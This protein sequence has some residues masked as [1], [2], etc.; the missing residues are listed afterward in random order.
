MKHLSEH[1]VG[2]VKIEGGIKTTVTDVDPNTGAVSWDVEYAADYLKLYKQVQELF[3][4]VNKAS[5][6]SNAEPFIKDWGQDVRQLRNSLRT[7]LRNNKAEEYARVKNM[8]EEMATG[9]T[10]SFNVGTG[11]QY[12]TK[13]AFRKTE[14][15]PKESEKLG[16]KPVKETQSNPGATLGPGPSA[17][18]DGV[19]DNYY[20]KLGYKPV[21]KKKLNKQ[22]KGIEVKQ[23]WGK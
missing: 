9:G 16:F 4:A 2:D 14:K 23:L 20:Y 6:Q 11:P 17:T 18:E 5:T 3:Q 12:A 13:Y 8:K 7:Y 10:A 22:A 15:T 1:K 21:D 19:K